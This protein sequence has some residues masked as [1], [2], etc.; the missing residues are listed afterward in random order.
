MEYRLA[1]WNKRV[2]IANMLMLKYYKYRHCII[3][4]S[5]SDKNNKIYL[6]LLY[7]VNYYKCC[8]IEYYGFPYKYTYET[9]HH[10]I[11]VT[12]VIMN[13]STYI[14]HNHCIEC[15]CTW[16]YNHSEEEF[17]INK[18]SEIPVKLQNALLQV[19][20]ITIIE[21]LIDFL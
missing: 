11:Y 1:Y 19:S 12:N 13:C 8:N 5:I 21:Y 15:G 20:T 18:F 9:R 16:S 14:P 7:I 10:S 4:Q 3:N 6:Y 2:K 17:I